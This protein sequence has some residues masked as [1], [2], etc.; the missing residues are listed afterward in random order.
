MIYKHLINTPIM[1]KFWSSVGAKV[2]THGPYIY[3][4]KYIIKWINTQNIIKL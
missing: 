2:V 1:Y 4:Q 3:I